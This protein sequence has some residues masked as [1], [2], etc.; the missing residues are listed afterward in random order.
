[1][2]QNNIKVC[3]LIP[4]FWTGH[5]PSSGILAQIQNHE[6][7]DFD[8]SIWSL[9]KPP[10]AFDPEKMLK[11]AGLRYRAFPMGSS[12]LDIRVLLPLVRRLR[13][14]K[15][16]IL[17]CHLLR[18]NLYGSIAAR[19]AGTKA[20][21]CTIR[22]I[23]EY[24]TSPDLLSR[25]LRLVERLTAGWVAKYVA[26]SDNVRR[27]IIKHLKF[28]PEKIITILNAV[29]LAP[30]QQ[31]RLSGPSLRAQLGLSPEALVI[32]SVGSLIPRKNY[33]SLIRCLNELTTSCPVQ[34][35]LIGEGE[36]RRSLEALAAE[37]DLA[38]KVRLP[39]FRSDIPEVLAAM[40]IFAF[41]SLGEGLPRALME[42]MAA[43][44]PCVVTEVGGNAEA[45]VD[46]ETGYVISPGD[47]PGLKA[48]LLRLIQNGE[49]RK[50]FGAAGKKRAFTLFNPKR[51]AAEYV[52]LYRSVL[53]QNSSR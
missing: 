10:P 45:V 9:Y 35:L 32:G 48:A 14:E 3:H 43:G 36:E 1:M 24:V 31:P 2:T 11:E 17:H 16:D 13:A 23:D 20:V 26:V 49:L 22:N 37:L 42:A 51:L 15:P 7:R 30:F 12:F 27:A 46:G 53:N 41:P 47:G 4:S 8:F 38:N 5:G 44:L 52:D 29:D 19:L 21:I 34:L 6:A 39:G 33:A 28:S 40:D 50:K 25:S 18:A